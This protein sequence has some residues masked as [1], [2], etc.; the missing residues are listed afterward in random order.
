M[1]LGCRTLLLPFQIQQQ[2]AFERLPDPVLLVGEMNELV[3]AAVQSEE[4][5]KMVR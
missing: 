2:L 5:R 1:A 3:E 4:C